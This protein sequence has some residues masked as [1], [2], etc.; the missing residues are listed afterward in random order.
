MIQKEI[1]FVIKLLPKS[2]AYGLTPIKVS[3]TEIIENDMLTLTSISAN[4]GKSN[5]LSEQLKK[6]HG[7]ALPNKGRATG[8][9]G[10]RAR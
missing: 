4:I 6:S 9:D 1:G 8:R 3:N 5:K 10:A 7:M 2:A